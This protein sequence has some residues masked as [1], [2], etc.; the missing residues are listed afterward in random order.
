MST[1]LRL[2]RVSKSFGGLQAV[3]DISFELEEGEILGL[4]GPNGAG[5]TTLINLIAGADR[6]TA[7]RITL[8]TR[9]VTGRPPFALARLGVARTFQIVR[10][11]KDMTVWENVV[12]GAL[13][14]GRGGGCTP[15]ERAAET[16]EFVGLSGLAN[17]R[18]GEI[19]LAEQKRVQFA[20]ALAMNPSVLLLDEAMA[21][22]NPGELDAAVD[23]VRAVHRR[24]VSLIVIEHLMRVIMGLSHRVIVMHHG[25][26]L[27]HGNPA[28]V[29][30]DPQVVAAY[31]GEQYSPRGRAGALRAVRSVRRHAESDQRRNGHRTP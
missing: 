22:L 4:I 25:R 31:F 24:G 11:F 3:R 20:H 2:D 18:A 23:L 30:R 17:R 26:V 15:R 6:P 21:G 9:D 19:G 14:A 27:A 7:G 29:V 28:D 10:V 8:G 12:V 16:L 13:F 5:K 1:A